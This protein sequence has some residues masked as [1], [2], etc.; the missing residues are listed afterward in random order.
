MSIAL[1]LVIRSSVI[2]AAG[3][4]I[5]ALLRR[6]SAALRHA[7]L[8]S[9][10]VASISSL[11]LAFLLPAWEVSVPMPVPPTATPAASVPAIRYHASTS[12]PSRARRD[13]AVLV[14][15]VWAA[16]TVA[17]LA[18]LLASLGR[19]I[20]IGQRARHVRDRRW[21]DATEKVSAAYGLKR[22]VVVLQTDAPDLMATWGVFRPRVLLPSHAT[23]WSDERIRVV[24]SHELAHIQRHDWLVQFSA[25]LF[26]TA[27]WFNPLL[28][29]VCTRLRRASEQACDDVVLGEGVEP[30]SYA[31]FISPTPLMM[32]VALG[33]VLTVADLALGAYERALEPK[34]LVSLPGG[35]FDVY[36]KDFEASAGPATEWFT[37][38]L[39]AK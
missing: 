2:L 27:Y 6:R 3:L 26:R 32:V 25:E 15:A 12:T 35:H 18:L 19:I 8:A 34:R 4:A 5:E 7:V 20:R 22:S 39:L 10:I 9:A 1:D 11:P 36:V 31:A 13:P 33:D 30:G 24:V 16:G 37:Q 17:G 21:T 38:H 28:W 29:I 14:G 23:E